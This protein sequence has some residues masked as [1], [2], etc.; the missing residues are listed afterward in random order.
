MV[1]SLRGRLACIAIVL[2][3]AVAALACGDTD[4]PPPVEKIVT[5][6]VEVE[7]IVE[8]PVEVEKVGRSSASSRRPRQRRRRRPLNPGS[9]GSGHL[10]DG[11]VRGSDFPKYVEL[12]RGPAG[13][14]WTGYVIS[15]YA[16]Q[17]Y[18]YSAQRFDWVPV[19][20]DGF[21]T[22]LAK[23]TVNGTEFWTTEVSLKSGVVWSDGEELDG[24]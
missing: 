4:A 20:A 7:K 6:T 21:P 12:P 22:P 13:S 16:T 2:V 5:V 9:H 23:E 11:A 17:L 3:I 1:D 10:Q 8:V 14:V 18:G 24:G 15:G 19:A